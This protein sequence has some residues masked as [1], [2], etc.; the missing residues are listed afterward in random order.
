MA[1]SPPRVLLVED[2]PGLVDVLTLHLAQ[3][4]Y[5]PVVATDGLQALRQLDEAPPQA[6]I[7]DLMVPEVSGFRLIQLIKH[8]YDSAAIPVLVLTALSFE[9][10]AEVI[11]AGADDFLTKPCEPA[12]VVRRVGALLNQTR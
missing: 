10:A 1:M 8:S 4:G 2:E 3:A 7:L 9:E 11:R 6:V 5:E 12:E